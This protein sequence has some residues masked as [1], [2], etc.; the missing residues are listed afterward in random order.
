MR[1]IP[2]KA[3]VDINKRF[4]NYKIS[5]N[6]ISSI[7]GSTYY[8]KSDKMKIA[9]VFKSLIKGHFFVD[10]N[11][12]TAL[13]VLQL[14]CKFNH[15]DLNIDVD[16]IISIAANNFSVDEISKLIFEGE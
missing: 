10:G 15:I 3:I 5:E 4:S 14:L 2:F 1:I 8:Y 11:K 13:A 6:N 7:Y 9:S 16:K 12:R